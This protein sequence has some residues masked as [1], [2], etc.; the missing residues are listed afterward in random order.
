MAG[1][2]ADVKILRVF[3]SLVT[4]KVKRTL[5]N[6]QMAAC[7]MTTSTLSRIRWKGIKSKQK[8]G[9]IRKIRYFALL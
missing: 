7:P 6:G 5:T 3:L 1:S 2:T 4:L 9:Q 8:P